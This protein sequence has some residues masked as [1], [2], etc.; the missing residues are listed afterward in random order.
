MSTT[1]ER[2][3]RRQAESQQ[4]L[5]ERLI[6]QLR[7]RGALEERLDELERFEDRHSPSRLT[8]MV[9]VNGVV[10]LLG[11]FL[12]VIGPPPAESG[13]LN[14]SWNLAGGVALAI[15]AYTNLLAFYFDRRYG[16]S[17]RLLIKTL[18]GIEQDLSSD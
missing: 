17:E 1:G 7:N 18:L 8:I 4:A 10:F 2:E 14:L 9:V 11:L 12:I 5:A 6:H 16:R 15:A 3:E 13:G